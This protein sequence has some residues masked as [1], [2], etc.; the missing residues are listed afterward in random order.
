MKST[1]WRSIGAVLAGFFTAAILSIAT[2]QILE[3]MGIMNMASFKTNPWW[4]ILLVILYRFIFN[5]TGC[6]VTAMLAPDKPMKHAMII[7]V[8]GTFLG[9]MGS[10]MMW[11]QAVAWYN[12]AII[13]ISIPSAWIG[14]TLFILQKTAK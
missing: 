8:A 11:D 9:I 13:L 14:A 6:Y 2:D 10:I 1:L 3:R 4:I 7:G 5:V 12:I